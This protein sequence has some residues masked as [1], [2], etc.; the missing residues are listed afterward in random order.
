MK[1]INILLIAA[2]NSYLAFAQP[3]KDI[4]ND[5]L[6]NLSDIE[7]QE[8]YELDKANLASG[9]QE[10]ID[11]DEINDYE[12]R[13]QSILD[14]HLGECTVLLRKNGDFPISS[15]QK[16]IHLYGNGIRYTVKGG[17]GSGD[18]TPRK[19]DTVETAFKNAGYEILTNDYLD[20]FDSCYQKA[21]DAYIKSIQAEFDYENAYGFVANHFSIVMNEP[22]CDLPVQKEGDLALY[23]LSRNSGE[24]FDRSYVK[25]D[26]LL[27]DTERNT[28]LTLARGFKKFMLV[29]NTSGPVDLSGLDEVKNILVL[30]QLGANT[31]NALVDL[32]TGKKYPSGKLAT[33]WAKSDQYAIN[34]GNFTDTD[35]TEGIY[36]GYR[37]FDTADV[38]V[39]FPFGYG[40]S[41]TEFESSVSKVDLKGDKVSVKSTVKNVGKYKGKEVLELYLSKPND[42]LDEPYQVLVNFGKTDELAPNKKENVKL[43]FHLADFA[44]YD[45]QLQSYVLNA[46]NYIVRIGNSSR[47]TVPCAIIEVPSRVIVKKVQNQLPSPSFQ[48]LKLRSYKEDSKS[49]LNQVKKF[50]LDVKSIK[51]TVVDYDKPF[52]I[53]EAVKSISTEEKVKFVIGAHS[54]EPWGSY[55]L[56]VAGSA[57]EIYKYKDYKPVILSDGPAGIHIAR[58]YFINEYG[59][60]QSTEGV[61][62]DRT[63][64]IVPDDARPSIEFL[65]P[66]VPENVTL[67]HQYT[68][69]L[70]IATAVAQSWS[71]KFAEKCGDIVGTEMNVFNLNLWLAPAMNIHRSILNGRNFEY[72][73]EDPYISGMMASY[74]IKGVQKHKNA[75]TTLKHYIANN[76]ETNRS[77]NSSNMS[78][79]AFREIYLRG[80]ELAIKYGNP[81]AI[82]SSYNLINGVHVNQHVGVIANVLRK[83]NNYNNIIMTDWIF[84]GMF[85]PGSKY[86][87]YSPYEIIKS[88][89]D[90]IM[91]GNVDFYNNVLE[92]VKEN[93][94]TMEELEAC[95]SRIYEFIL[96]IQD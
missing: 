44:S 90:V 37:Y 10:I 78:E 19:F 79:R 64:A 76:K 33:T 51:T 61:F 59:A 45:S 42:Q 54:T 72:Y 55:P 2:L 22:E 60:P 29:L 8:I 71:V 21:Y 94:L 70:P 66:H 50:K 80:Y 39:L 18:I 11:E 43:E 28:I 23:V 4:I 57:G 14:E 62:S 93:K 96:E 7:N 91:P 83:E 26:V 34:M 87:D 95:V 58:D 69:P 16:R 27:T 63:L 1:F 9:V 65:F 13:N 77:F 24:G 47:N 30:S 92:A 17:L 36:V 73:S 81:K 84:N 35:Y 31:S 56:T 74:V 20:A 25:G 6:E 89:V 75:F 67:Y 46:G 15:N 40:L 38:D 88:S 12:I 48:D 68:T 86:P 3:H 82:M 85:V 52:K 5:N 53:N 32:I 41:Y 49:S